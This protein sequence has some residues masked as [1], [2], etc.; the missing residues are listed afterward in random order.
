MGAAYLGVYACMHVS[1]FSYARVRVHISVYGD[2]YLYISGY[3]DVYVCRPCVYIIM[4]G[5]DGIR[6]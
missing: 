1:V 2:I 3:V 5:V 6:I 4:V